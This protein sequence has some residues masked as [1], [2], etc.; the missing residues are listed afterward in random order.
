M[1]DAEAGAAVI[2]T[3]ILGNRGNVGD[4]LRIAPGLVEGVG[5]VHR[6]MAELGVGRNNQLI[7]LVNAAGLKLIVVFRGKRAD[8]GVGGWIKLGAVTLFVQ[9]LVNAASK[10][11]GHVEHDL[12]C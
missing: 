9:V 7:L 4:A 11:I 5:A 12:S 8:H 10:Q 3:G 2:E 1:R 6:Q